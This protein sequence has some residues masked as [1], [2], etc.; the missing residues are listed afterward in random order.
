LPPPPL[1]EDEWEL[2]GPDDWTQARNIAK[3]H[4]AKLRALHE[5]WIMEASRYNVFPLDDRF[6]ERNNPDVAGRPQLVRGTSQF[7]FGGTGRLNEWS[8]ISIKNKS[9]AVTAEIVVPPSG[10][11]GVII[12]QGGRFG[13]WSLY[14][15]DGHAKYCYNFFGIHLYMI[16]G[17]TPIPQGTHEVRMEFK[18]DGGGPGKGGTAS[19]FVDGEKAGEGRIEQT[20]PVAF[21]IDETCDIGRDTGAPVSPD[22][23]SHRNSFGGEVNWVHIDLRGDDHDREVSARERFKASMVWE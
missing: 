23:R 6:V 15:K 22:Y 2:Y 21:S 7:L 13:G 12:S 8:T 18:Y 5:L 10:A 4:P 20:V 11:E 9:Y 3:E 19:L 14:A 17:A 1:E 16:E